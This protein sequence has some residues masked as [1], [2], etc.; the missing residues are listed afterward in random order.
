MLLLATLSTRGS[1]AV[2]VRGIVRAL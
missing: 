1:Q 2:S